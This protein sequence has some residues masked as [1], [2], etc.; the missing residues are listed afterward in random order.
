M[1]KE[2]W[3]LIKMLFATRPSDFVY[4][5]LEVV[6]MKHFPFEGYKWLM[7]CGRMVCRSDNKEKIQKEM[8]TTKFVISKNHEKI[9]LMQALACNDSWARYYLAYL[10]EWLKRGFLAPMTANYYVSKFESEAYANEDSP[11][12]LKYY[13]PFGI[14]KYNIKGAKKLYK[15]LG[16]TPAT[17]KEYVKTL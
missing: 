8:L 3:T 14:N 4:R 17:W 7:W 13:L 6:E 9:H 1:L 15:K 12:Y 5:D 11:N 2:L 16:G 10:W